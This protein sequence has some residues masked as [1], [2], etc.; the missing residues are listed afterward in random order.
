[1]QGQDFA[2]WY[3]LYCKGFGAQEVLEAVEQVE[4]LL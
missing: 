4:A 3:Y 1:M 2:K